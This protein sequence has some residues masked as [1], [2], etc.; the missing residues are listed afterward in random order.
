MRALLRVVARIMRAIVASVEHAEQRR[1]GLRRLAAYAADDRARWLYRR[2]H[3]IA[4]V[5]GALR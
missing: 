2:T 1:V 4:A 5:A 3:P